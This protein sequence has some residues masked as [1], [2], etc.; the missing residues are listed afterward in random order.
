[1]LPHGRCRII[2]W[3]F[4]WCDQVR[5]RI[6][7][8]FCHA[9]GA[10]D[11]L[12]EWIVC[13]CHECLSACHHGRGQQGATRNATNEFIQA[14]YRYQFFIILLDLIAQPHHGQIPWHGIASAQRHQSGASLFG[15]RLPC[16]HH[17]AE[18]IELGG[19]I[20]VM[21]AEFGAEFHD[22]TAV[23]AEWADGAHDG[24]S[25]AHQIGHHGRDL[26][27]DDDGVDGIEQFLFGWCVVVAVFEFGNDVILDLIE[28]LL[29]STG[30]GPFDRPVVEAVRLDQ[31]ADAE[32][33]GEAG[34]THDDDIVL[35][36]GSG[37]DVIVLDDVPGIELGDGNGTIT[38]QLLR[39]GELSD[40]PND[41]Q[42]QDAG[43]PNGQH[44]SQ[45]DQCDERQLHNLSVA[46]FD[47][48][49]EVLG[50]WLE[51]QHPVVVVVVACA[52]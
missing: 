47:D 36:L 8:C 30:D 4:D 50:R 13:R 51:I 25:V 41:G 14:R 5:E 9:F 3:C 27:I 49:V 28:L 16:H 20:D 35:A 48:G 24:P 2:P 38:W 10:L 22:M 40:L 32:L 46:L 33:S 17:V 37:N 15:G 45:T 18:P 23:H 31:V 12:H 26:R 19:N 44:C 34:R 21:G 52:G 29:G 43:T 7:G 1:M 39:D 11:R 6:V 42:R